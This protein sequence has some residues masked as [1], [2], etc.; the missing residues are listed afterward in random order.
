MVHFVRADVI[1]KRVLPF[2]SLR[3]AAVR[4]FTEELYHKQALW[5]LSEAT[6]AQL[7]VLGDM[8]SAARLGHVVCV[9]LEMCFY[10]YEHKSVSGKATPEESVFFAATSGG[11]DK[12]GFRDNDDAEI[13]TTREAV[14]VL[15]KWCASSMY[16]R[17]PLPSE[18]F[19]INL[20]PP[21][22][23]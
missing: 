22:V 12:K 11:G 18:I 15:K 4:Q 6:P 1:E 3:S 9:L 8:D 2:C 10:L 14:A 20:L 17:K 19:S 13:F 5:M 7:L 21:R 16:T 23:R